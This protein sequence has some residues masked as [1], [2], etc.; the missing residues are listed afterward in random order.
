MRKI[1]FIKVSA[2]DLNRVGYDTDTVQLC[3]LFFKFTHFKR[4]RNRKWTGLKFL[5]DLGAY[6]GSYS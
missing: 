5:K 6:D 3:S 4:N 1:Q 2:M